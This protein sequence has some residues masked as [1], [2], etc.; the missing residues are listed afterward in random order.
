MSCRELHFELN[1][2]PSFT[3][4]FVRESGGLLRGFIGLHAMISVEKK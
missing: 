3:R 4:V 1:R 2:L